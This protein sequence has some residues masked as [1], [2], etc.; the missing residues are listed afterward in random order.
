[1]IR[2]NKRIDIKTNT[3]GVTSICTDRGTTYRT[4][5]VR[6]EYGTP[7]TTWWDKQHKSELREW[8]KDALLGE[9]DRCY[10]RISAT[11][12][13]QYYLVYEENKGFNQPHDIVFARIPT[14][15]LWILG[16]QQEIWLHKSDLE[17]FS[18]H[19]TT[20]HKFN[21]ELANDRQQWYKHILDPIEQYIKEVA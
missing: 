13:L 16:T 12:L 14:A 19:P 10:R 6:T 5:L 11:H 18:L 20:S 3:Q 15:Q 7:R 17:N 9:F 1:M 4:S 21:L 8:Q 2:Y